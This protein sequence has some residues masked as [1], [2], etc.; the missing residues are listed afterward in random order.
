MNTAP[1]QIPG[2]SSSR[3]EQTRRVEREA[4]IRNREHAALR[5]L[6]TC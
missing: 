1:I 6:L 3:D 4:G 2:V 5:A